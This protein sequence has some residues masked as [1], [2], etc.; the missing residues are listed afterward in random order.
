MLIK[1]NPKFKKLVLPFIMMDFDCCKSIKYHCIK[2]ILDDEKLN[3]EIIKRTC[4]T[5]TI[6]GE[7]DKETITRHVIK[8]GNCSFIC[9]VNGK[10]IYL[11]LFNIITTIPAFF[12]ER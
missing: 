5:A 2:L 9:N 7:G 10:N 6:L 4:T 8:F 12:I 1:V 11:P 3:V